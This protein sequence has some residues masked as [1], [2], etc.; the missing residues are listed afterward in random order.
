MMMTEKKNSF[1]Y[2]QTT[3]NFQL[4][5]PLLWS[6]ISSFW[7]LRLAKEQKK[8]EQGF[9]RVK[10]PNFLF[11]CA[12][13]KQIA[14]LSFSFFLHQ[15]L[16]S[17]FSF[18]PATHFPIGEA[19]ACARWRCG[20][21][22]WVRL[23]WMLGAY[24]T[25]KKP[26][27]IVINICQIAKLCYAFFSLLVLTPPKKI[28]PAIQLMTFFFFLSL[29]TRNWMSKRRVQRLDE[30]GNV[31]KENKFMAFH[32]LRHHRQHEQS[33]RGKKGWKF[34]WETKNKKF[35]FHPA[36]ID[37]FFFSQFRIKEMQL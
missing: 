8:M 37:G 35:F 11:V 29:I 3:G 21:G 1:S 15:N 18:L 22:R 16:L 7:G 10:V 9:S 2:T 33:N 17:V 36:K 30:R 19:F 4:V 24:S 12:Y 26:L 6:L 5:S 27:R 13:G 14:F 34:S 28:L 31:K 25:Y 20:T 23:S 32:S